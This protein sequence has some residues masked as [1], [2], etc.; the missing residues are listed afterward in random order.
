VQRAW[1]P[2]CG[3]MTLARVMPAECEAREPV[4][5]ATACTRDACSP[6]SRIF[7]SSRN[8]GMTVG[9]LSPL[10][11]R[12]VILRSSLAGD[13]TWMGPPT[14]SRGSG[15]RLEGERMAR[16]PGGPERP[17]A[18]K[19]QQWRGAAGRPSASRCDRFVPGN[20]A[21][22]EAKDRTGTQIAAT[23]VPEGNPR[24]RE[25]PESRKALEEARAGLLGPARDPR[26][27]R[28]APA[29][30]SHPRGGFPRGGRRVGNESEQRIA[31]D[32]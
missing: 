22:R 7:R 5:R 13:G 31:N 27:P 18:V 24:D 28:T 32:E 14:V 4:P 30:P 26:L 19:R 2:P 15:R 10:P 11:R 29:Y 1:A 25:V 8:S 21:E 6:G 9:A 23:R 20:R 3:G 17:L 12:R 16:D